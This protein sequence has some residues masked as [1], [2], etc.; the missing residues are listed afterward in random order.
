MHTPKRV[1]LSHIRKPAPKRKP[2]PSSQPVRYHTVTTA[3]AFVGC[4]A[5]TVRNHLTAG[6]LKPDALTTDDR[7]L[8]LPATVDAFR[9][10]L[11]IGEAR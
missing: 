3:G 9:Q 7:P 10:L 2:S 11:L 4:S 5:M 6:T 8:F 1:P